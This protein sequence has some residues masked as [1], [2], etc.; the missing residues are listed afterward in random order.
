MAVKSTK[1]PSIG[2][3]PSGLEASL[4]QFLDS[5]KEALEVRL[6]QRGD[7]LDR[8]VTLRELH[9]GGVVHLV[10]GKT[11][12][13]ADDRPSSVGFTGAAAVVQ[14]NHT[15]PPAP[16]NLTASGSLSHILLE[17]DQPRYGNHS[18]TEIWRSTVDKRAG[19][20]L[21]GQSSHTLYADAVDPDSICYYWARFI[22][23]SNIEGQW[24]SLAGTRGETGLIPGEKIKTLS[25]D[26]IST[27][28]LSAFSANLGTVTAGLMES[29]SGQF[30]VDLTN[31]FIEVYQG[32]T[33][34]VRIGRL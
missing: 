14:Y 20:V 11:V 23:T 8:A 5:I 27:T 3:V 18:H 32:D 1:I 34:R 25:A 13:Q 21:L 26:K 19:A 4:R 24:N 6:G 16:A 28:S 10:E 33:L 31:E 12:Q 22:S 29:A 2:K 7:R 15:P 17:W 9:Q 30:V